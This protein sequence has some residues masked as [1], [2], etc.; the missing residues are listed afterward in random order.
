MIH[1]PTCNSENLDYS[2]YC[3]QCGSP[4]R[5]GIPARLRKGQWFTVVLLAVVLSCIMTLAI[6]FISP[7]QPDSHYSDTL[8]AAYQR[9]VSIEPQIAEQVPQPAAN[10][11]SSAGGQQEEKEKLVRKGQLVLGMV[12]I[13]HSN[14]GSV[15]KFPSVVLN[16]SW[17]ALP[18][19]AC[20]GGDKWFFQAGEGELIPIEGGLWTRGDPVGFW[21]LG[22]ERKFPGPDFGAW[23]QDQPVRLFSIETGK[24]SEPM[25]L[26]PY[27]P[28]GAFIYSELPGVMDPGVFLQGGRVVGWSFG[29]VL[30]GAYMWP[31]GAAQDLLYENYVDD[32]YRE[33]FAGGREEH[34]FNAL[35]MEKDSAP[36]RQ[37]HLFAE[38]F[39]VQPKLSPQDTPLRL[40]SETVYPYIVK[41][42]DRIMEEGGYQ[43]VATLAESPMLAEIRSPELLRDVIRATEKTYG[44]RSAVDFI[45]GQGADLLQSLAE[46]KEM[47]QQLHL[48]LYLGWIKERLDEGDAQRG[49]QV[50]NRAQPY[51][52]ESPELH[53]LAVE[54]AL[55]GGDWEEAERLLYLREYPVALRETRMLLTDRISDLKGRENKIVVRFAP[56]ARDIPVRVR[57]NNEIDQDFIVDT[58]ASFVTIP[59][60]TVRSLGLVEKV[61][62]HQQ[63]V[64][65]AGGPVDARAV[66]LSSVELQ[67]WAVPNVQALILDLPNRP[68]LGLLGLNFLNSFRVDMRTDEGLLILEPK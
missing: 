27:G 35:T 64:Q 1:C 68:G 57:L 45:E 53:L 28:Q 44:V 59:S 21:R 34:F 14:V 10:D 2:V 19:R 60:S 8:G 23:R 31:Q 46:G 3:C 48:D 7:G 9:G 20:I 54:L 6:R 58:G 22:N 66:T 29:E 36:Q 17:L 5:K 65:T 40:S 62:Q 38:G 39:W 11:E 43:Y 47:V 55:A 67:G 15:A 63:V 32:F 52:K 56:G 33:T 49:W 51:F 4:V 30:R 50:Y 61:S 26:E 41:L 25:V 18:S 37:L 13:M 16:G 12:S 42:A 24:L